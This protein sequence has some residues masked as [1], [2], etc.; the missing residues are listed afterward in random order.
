M[1]LTVYTAVAASLLIAAGCSDKTCNKAGGGSSTTALSS[2]AATDGNDDD[3]SVTYS[4]VLPAADA[5]GFEYTLVMEYDNGT[6]DD[7]DYVLTERVLGS[8]APATVT[9][10]DFSIHTGTPQSARQRYIKLTPDHP[11]RA[12]EMEDASSMVCYFIID[13]D[14]TITLTNASLQPA[15]SSLNYS[16]TRR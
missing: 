10:G 5:P 6:P 4:G 8:D 9:K 13:N 15:E 7:G 11:D 12:S 14:S 16:L 3:I 1:K 2:T